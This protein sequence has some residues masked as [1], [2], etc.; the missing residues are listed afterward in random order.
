MTALLMNMA[1]QRNKELRDYASARRLAGQR[2]LS[3]RARPATRPLG[4]VT[5]R[6][7]GEADADALERVAGRDSASRPA[8]EVL[9]AEVG[10]RLIAAISITTGEVVA[11]PFSRTDAAR[12]L[13]E[14]RAAQLSESRARNGHGRRRHGLRGLRGLTVRPRRS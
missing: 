4:E 6:R 11:D 1:E 12:S 8:G 2:R 13:L 9:G 3:L 5:I 10:G 14:L 7:L